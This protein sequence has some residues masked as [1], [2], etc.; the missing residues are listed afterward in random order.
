M[1]DERQKERE[2]REGEEMK[3]K[4]SRRCPDIQSCSRPPKR[5]IERKRDRRREKKEFLN[6]KVIQEE[7]RQRHECC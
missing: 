2:K 7:E 5:E 6:E 4:S 3:S 1:G